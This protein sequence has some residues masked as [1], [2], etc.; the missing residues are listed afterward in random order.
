M[1]YVDAS[2]SGEAFDGWSEPVEVYR[3]LDDDD[4]PW[5]AVKP[6]TWLRRV[7]WRKRGLISPF[8][9][10]GNAG[11]AARALHGSKSSRMSS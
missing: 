2:T 9:V 3:S 8:A 1:A 5:T 11:Q 4:E 7:G 10:P 6:W